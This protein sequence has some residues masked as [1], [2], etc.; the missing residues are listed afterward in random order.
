MKRL[1]IFNPDCEQ[2]IAHGGI[3]YMPPANIV[4][5]ADDLGFLLAWLG[6][7]GDYVLVKHTPDPSFVQEVCRPL[8]LPTEPVTEEALE[9]LPALVPEPWG[10]SPKM[11]HWLAQ[12]KMGEEWRP[13]QKDRYSRKTAREALHRLFS[14]IPLLEPEILPYVC[15]SLQDVEAHLDAGDWLIKAPWSSSGKGIMPLHGGIEQ[16]KQEWLSGVLR[17]QGYVMLERKLNKCKD[18]AMEFRSDRQGVEFIGLSV[19]STGDK[20][21]YQGNRLAS[22]PILEQQLASALGTHRLACLK[23]EMPRMLGQLLPDY[24]GF[25][26]VDMM[27]YQNPAGVFCLQPCL[28]INLRYN[29]GI[30][31][32]AL[33][34]NYLDKDRCGDFHIRFYPGKGEAL[35]ANNALRRDHPA[36]YK[37]NRLFTGYLNLTPVT[38]TTHFVASIRCY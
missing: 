27:V 18:F 31:A 24:R 17:R 36:V 22:S 38:E 32:L 35:R 29:M 30:V 9:Q 14:T 26:G 6:E 20:G 19:F 7:P 23:T 12:K 8:A 37:N 16:K 34:R 4:Q 13:E 21:E 5:M 3:H 10:M 25:L 33:S 15:S 11:C 1:F 28:E 2:A